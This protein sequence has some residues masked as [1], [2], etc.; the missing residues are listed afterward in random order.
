M[1]IGHVHSY[2]RDL[3]VYQG[4]PDANGYNNPSATTHLLVGGAGNDEMNPIQMA[5]DP[6]PKEGPGLSKWFAS[7][8]D[9]PWTVITDQGNHVGIG[10]IQI[11]DDSYL[12]FDY[13]RT[14]TGE[15]YDSFK[16]FRD[17]SSIR[18]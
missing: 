7:E 1:S 13:I 15:V 6:S 8:V 14:T 16:L 11:I 12:S 9:G 17:H 5:K 3:P 18:R 10:R 2:E 4:E